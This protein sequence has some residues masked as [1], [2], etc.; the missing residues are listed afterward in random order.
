MEFTTRQGT[1][2]KYDPFSKEPIDSVDGWGI[3]YDGSTG[4]T[5]GFLRGAGGVEVFTS[6]SD[7]RARCDKSGQGHLPPLPQHHR[8][9]SINQ[10]L[11]VT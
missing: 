2:I 6:E 9:H 1:P 5:P 10:E 3:W 8:G 11:A 4:Y 7:A